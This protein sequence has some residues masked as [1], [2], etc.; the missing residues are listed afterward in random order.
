MAKQAKKWVGTSVKR[1]EDARFLT[2]EAIFVDDMQMPGMLYCAILR[3]TYPHAKIKKIDVSEAKKC[4]G[5]V[6]VITGEDVKNYP[7]AP[8]MELSHFE[9]KPVGKY[10][11]AIA[12]DKVR[13]VGEAVAALAAVDRYV[14]ED[15][16]DLIKVEYEPLTPI[17]D[18]EKA[19]SKESPLLYPDWGDNVQLRVPLKSGD[20][21]KAFKEADRVIKARISEHRYSAF[22][23]EG[24]AAIASYKP[25]S[26]TLDVWISTQAV[27]Q[28]RAYIARTL[29]L[30]EQKISVVAPNV[31]GGFGTKLNW[32]TETIPCLL[33]MKTGRPVK[34]VENRIENII[35]GPHARDY[36]YNAEVA[37]KKDG[38]I[39]GVKADVIFDIGVESSH[40]GTAVAKCLIIAKYFLGQY[41]IKN[42][43][44][45]ARAVV[46]NKAFECSYR[47]FGKDA[48]S[49]LMERLINIMS[50]EL[51]IAPEEIRQKNYIQPNEFPYRTAT[52]ALYDS[53]NY[54]ELLKRVMKKADIPSL[55][56]EQA[57]LKKEGKH[58]MGIGIASFV[59]SAGSAV[60]DSFVNG[61]E[62]ATVKLMPEGGLILATAHPSLGQGIET[63]LA[64]VVADEFEVTPEDV[65]V[66][67]GETD[68]APYNMGGFSSRGAA[69]VVGATVTAARMVKEK[70]LR[71]GANMLKVEPGEVVL[72][73]GKILVKNEPSKCLTLTELARGATFFPGAIGVVPKDLLYTTPSLDATGYWMAPNPP[74]SWEPPV[75]L[76]C[77]HPCGAEVATVLID[78]E[79]GKITVPKHFIIYDCGTLINPDIVKNQYIGGNLQGVN[80]ILNEEICFDENAQPTT[81]TFMDYLIPSSHEIPEKIVF[82]HM[83]TPSPFTP[84]G[85]KGMGEA[86]TICSPSSIVNAVEDALGVTVTKTP[87]KPET[88]LGLIKEAKKKGTI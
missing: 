75:N 31:G 7:L 13:Y 64:Q 57:R 43:D 19:L 58:L 85:T 38:T 45:L 28:A 20:V 51:G 82:E 4:P 36:V 52:G 44:F 10:A 67:Y 55:R 68:K 49:R 12:V 78:V 70:A 63:T 8:G 39:L 3:S 17:V 62:G 86:G 9:L 72:K 54:P 48:S 1:K 66:I 60:P 47:A 29:K 25:K 84:L 33:S 46:T 79:T 73:E 24:R 53:G 40:R 42:F 69:W 80:G 56:K 59:Q 23:M 34:F 27:C 22:P 16:L 26:G 11:Y 2:G 6:A 71:I 5:V 18:M 21:D 83:E 87:L 76:Y 77:T 30:S 81:T 50:R 32:G 65:R 61:L 35:S 37:C 14:A 41:K 74:V 88:V 15:A